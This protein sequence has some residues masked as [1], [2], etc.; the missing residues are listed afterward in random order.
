M[1]RSLNVLT[2]RCFSGH[3]QAPPCLESNRYFSLNLFN[4][5]FTGGASPTGYINS[6]LPFL[7]LKTLDNKGRKSM[8]IISYNYRHGVE[9]FNQTNLNVFSTNF[10]SKCCLLSTCQGPSA[11][12]PP[13][14]KHLPFLTFFS[15][16]D[17]IKRQS[18][19]YS[20]FKLCFILNFTLFSPNKSNTKRV[21]D[22]LTSQ[23]SRK[24][25]VDSHLNTV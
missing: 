7:K 1:P 15:V 8:A 22:M 16:T 6:K 18:F 10:I 23:P 3:L 24:R 21:L 4:L 20:T 13:Q 11:V 19:N 25:P 9:K 17:P 2:E 14:N 5:L 12:H